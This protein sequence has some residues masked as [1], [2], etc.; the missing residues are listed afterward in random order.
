MDYWYDQQIRRCILQ[1]MRLFDNFKVKT[2]KIDNGNSE[3]YIRTPVRYA[4][5][6]RMVAHIL[7]HNSENVVS[8]APFMSAYITNL[9]IARDRLQEPRMVDK[10]QVAERKYDTSSKSYRVGMS[11]TSTVEKCMPI[12]YKITMG[13]EI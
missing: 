13:F 12:P 11:K 10:V 4:D 1:F 7:R 3:S 9:Q 8:S 2:G 5:M 6:S